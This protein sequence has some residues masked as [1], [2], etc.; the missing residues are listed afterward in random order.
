[1]AGTVRL[2]PRP[3][4]A[5]ASLT[6]LAVGIRIVTSSSAAVGC[7]AKVASKSA[8]VAF[9]FTANERRI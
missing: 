1:M 8:F 2:A 7:N 3:Y 9:I 5:A 4:S 6:Y